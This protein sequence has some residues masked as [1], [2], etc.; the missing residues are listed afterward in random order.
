[1]HCHNTAVKGTKVYIFQ[2]S[3]VM[4]VVAYDGGRDMLQFPDTGHG[5]A[6]DNMHQMSDEF[7]INCNMAR[8]YGKNEA[9]ATDVTDSLLDSMKCTLP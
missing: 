8:L 4:L 7:L 1:M 2:L 6:I 5:P 3:S 9:A